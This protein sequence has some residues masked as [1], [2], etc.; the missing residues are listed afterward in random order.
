MGEHQRSQ[1]TP[2]PPSIA[3]F[4][5]VRRVSTPRWEVPSCR[6]I[7][8]KQE[9]NNLDKFFQPKSFKDGKISLNALNKTIVQWYQPPPWGNLDM[10]SVKKHRKMRR[11]NNSSWAKNRGKSI[12]RLLATGKTTPD[13]S[14]HGGSKIINPTT[15]WDDTMRI[16]L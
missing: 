9:K 1:T 16:Q 12:E 3:H 10:E 11:E 13:R 8:R 2:P 6:D 14:L 4:M 15:P 7:H 5:S